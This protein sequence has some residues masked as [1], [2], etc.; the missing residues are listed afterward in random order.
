MS[1]FNDIYKKLNKE[2]KQ[3]I[4][5]INGP[6]MIIAGPGTGKT[7]TLTMRIANI[8]KKTDT[9]P[10][11]ILALTFTESGAKTMRERLIDIIGTA[12]YYVNINTF[13]SFC[14]N[15][16]HEFSEYFLISEDTT[17]LSEL[18]RIQLFKE[19][20]DSTD[21][22]LLRPANSPYYYINSLVNKI[23]ELKREGITPTKFKTI[24]DNEEK[25]VK[26]IDKKIN[27]RTNKPYSKYQKEQ[28]DL[29]KQKELLSIYKKYQKKLKENKRYDFEDMINLVVS[30]LKENQDSKL[31]LQEKY[32]YILVDEYQD[33]NSAQ[34][35]IIKLLTDHWEEPNIFVV[36]DD[37]QS[38]FRFQGAS[39]EN[40]L[41]FKKLFEKSKLITL[42]S[43]Y[44]SSQ[45]I[46][47][48][49]RSLIE[50][51]VLKLKEVDKNL[52]SKLKR[53]DIP[54]KIAQFPS[55]EIENYFLAQKIKE[56]I[57]K[58]TDPDKIAVLVKENKDIDD[59]KN[60]LSS[61]N[62]RFEI[63]T[64]K[65]ILEDSDINKLLLL[66]QV[67]ND[68]KTKPNND[69]DIF[70]L[71][72]FEFLN[73]DR[74]DILK[75]S[76]FA[77][78]KKMNII[79]VI[80]DQDIFNEIDLSNPKKLIDLVNDLNKWQESASNLTF[81]KFFENL[82]QES[83]FLDHILS[84]KYNISR[85]NTLN[86]LYNE[87]KNINYND[88][89]L[90][91]EKFLKNID[92][93]R[94]NNIKI[95]ENIRDEDKDA[96]KLITAHKSKG[97]EFDY[98]F[99]AKC[100][101]KK[102]G[103]KVFRDPLKLP[104]GI[105]KNVNLEDKE[106]NED[107]R[108]LF[109]V[110]LTRAKKQIFIT[111]ADKYSSQ[112]YRKESVPSM[113]MH[114]IDTKYTEKF[115][116]NSIENKFNENIQEQLKLPKTN[117]RQIEENDFLNSIISN[118]KL[119]VTALNTY[120]QCP[121]KFK[122]NNILKTPRAKPPHLA[123]GTAMH[124]SLENY[125][126]K[127]KQINKLPSKS[128]LVSEYKKA[129]ENEILHE[130]DFSRLLKKGKKVLD[131]YYKDNFKNFKKPIFTEYPFGLRNI[132]LGN[133]PLTG[134][135]DKIE[136]VDKDKKQV[137]VIDY[138]TGAPKSRNE[139]EGKTKYSDGDLLRQ[140]LFYKLL[141]QLDRN[142]NYKVVKGEFDFIEPKPHKKPKKEMFRYS[143]D[144]IEDLKILIKETMDEIRNL[145]FNRTKEYRL[146]ENCDFKNHCWPDGIPK[147]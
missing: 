26:N 5:A 129:L 135:V 143:R 117:N 128:Y 133:I 58:G 98:V 69:I 36:G 142:F 127:Y 86:T 63:S 8:L 55:G 65:N 139:I 121:Y 33:T 20:I 56:I 137:K 62:I 145:N 108:R 50:K 16:I 13:H 130:N 45:L 35:E 25:R 7:L 136:W 66:M 107:D 97:L 49:S 68:L 53:S 31:S 93:M 89:T 83:S 54:I 111:Y 131:E 44:R 67:I 57:K 112:G 42:T 91:L 71:L 126:K 90:N 27:P 46:L 3:A 19:I 103:N 37:E 76:R 113:F 88:H 2:Q 4:E 134:K 6:I 22:D 43:N 30:K 72:N 70:T 147:K 48:A 102:W 123:F 100:I 140:I 52:K 106:K 59:I 38:I 144:Q 73:L 115:D 118:F 14:I 17:T 120:L 18:E 132:R 28:Q 95:K 138:K 84:D 24:L 109:Y 124:K 141:S 39:L 122:L 51:N 146:C 79:D 74:L 85:I 29:Q 116:T 78:E 77:T 125:F 104:S 80:L 1:K 87:I 105:L 11:D 60:S 64:E 34:N 101:D 41:Y 23:Q 12:A 96:V 82:I 81:T 99:I 94:E 75:L 119:S 9:D 32:L 114:E 10:H 21:L 92:L 61:V 47:D 110:A 40:V 15:V